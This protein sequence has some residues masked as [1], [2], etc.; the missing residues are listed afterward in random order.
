MITRNFLALIVFAFFIQTPISPY[1]GAP[2][3][4]DSGEFHDHNA[5][6]SLWDETRGCHYDH[7]HGQ[8]PFTQAVVNTFPDFDLHALLGNVGI[9]HTNPSSEMENT[10]KH[11]GMKW[12]VTL[13]HTQGCTGGIGSPTGVNAL[14]IQYHAF[15]D[16]SMEFE[17]RVHSAVGLLRQCRTSNPT[18]YGYVF[19]NQFQDYGQRITPYQGTVL[20]YPDTPVPAYGS[21]FVPYFSVD[22]VGSVS[23]CRPSLTW[24]LSRNTNATSTWASNGFPQR[25]IGSPLFGLDVRVRDNYQLLKWADNVY[26][27]TFDWLCSNDGGL[28]YAALT[29]CRY[30]NSTTRV[31]G[32]RGEIQTAWDNL[33]GFD[34]NPVAGRITADGYVT[35]FGTLNLSCIGTGVDCHPIKLVN[36]FTGKYISQFA[37]V[38]GKGSFTPENLPERDVCFTSGGVLAV[39]DVPGALPSG[40][41]GAEN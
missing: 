16:Y 8:N 4:P 31:H 10:H 25:T 26:P 24:V 33:A 2:L 13:S 35:H 28:T 40:W 41:I 3:C 23:Q 7:E 1:S 14:V 37:L 11:G 9:G 5:F 29:G 12:D 22:C 19:V 30:N 34:T 15:G 36:A 21:G 6:H 18:D 38:S 27:F 32:V 17:S 20:P 39:C